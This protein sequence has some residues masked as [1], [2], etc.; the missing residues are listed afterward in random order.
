MRRLLLWLALCLL[1]P[2]AL[3]APRYTVTDI[4]EGDYSLYYGGGSVISDRGQVVG[5][6][7]SHAFLWD[8]GK[9]TPFLGAFATGWG[10]GEGS[11]DDAGSASQGPSRA[12]A[13]NNR[14]H[15]AGG[16]GGFGPLSMSGLYDC[17]PFFYANGDMLNLAKTAKWRGDYES[18][19]AFGINDNDEVVGV[20]AHHGFY[21]SRGKRIEFG[22]LHNLQTG[23]WSYSTIRAIN[24]K[25]QF[26]GESTVPGPTPYQP[27]THAVLWIGPKHSGHWKDLGVP[28][29]FDSSQ[30][31]AIN[32]QGMIVGVTKAD[33]DR[34]R[35]LVWREGQKELL[36]LLAGT[37]SSAAQGVNDKGEVVG[38]CSNCPRYA[39][40]YVSND[41]AVLWRHNKAINL[42]TLL[43][44]GSGWTLHEARSINNH[45]WIV[46]T[47]T[48]HDRLH[49]FLLTPPQ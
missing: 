1:A 16:T 2:P 9:L 12:N 26:V 13:I 3:A 6:M 44:P 49:I 39:G 32:N 18:F 38:W 29:G 28:L 48:F 8:N 19:E 27:N 10:D 34:R 42:N 4:G 17:F 24:N 20:H 43:T 25:G 11:P 30:A 37:V 35:A 47:G 33:N 23:T 31:V 7:N 45:G 41:T 36:P 15:V 46:G 5:E 14:G 40:E 22:T 21:W